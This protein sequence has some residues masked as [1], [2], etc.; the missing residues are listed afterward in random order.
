[1]VLDPNVVKVVAG[2]DGY[3]L[4]FSRAPI[5]WHRDG[6]DPRTQRQRIC[7]G[8]MRH[9]GLYAYRVGALRALTALPVSMLERSEKLEQLRALENGMTIAVVETER[10]TVGVDV[11]ADVKKVEKVLQRSLD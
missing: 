3:A 6:V 11:P 10:E 4:Y 7:E 9:V 8:A 1:M 5:P 2:A